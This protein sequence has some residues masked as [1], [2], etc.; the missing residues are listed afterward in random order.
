MAYFLGR[1]VIVNVKTEHGTAGIDLSG[2]YNTDPVASTW[3][4]SDSADTGI[5]VVDVTG[6]DI[7]IGVTDEDITYMGK[8]SVLKAEIKKETTLSITRK[9]STALWENVFQS[10]R[11]GADSGSIHLGLSAPPADGTTLHYGYIIAITLSGA[12]DVL[13]LRSCTVT[14][15][16]IS[17]NADGTTDETLEFIT[18][19][20]P[21]VS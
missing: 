10:A 16:T 14:G 3:F 18:Q 6:L 8:K 13:T 5:T 7:G 17:L 21:V 4:A 2:A 19:V 15:H 20:A 9:K 12:G 11:W 1:D